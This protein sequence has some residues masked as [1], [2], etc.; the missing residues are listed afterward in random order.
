MKIVAL[1]RI[2][3]GAILAVSLRCPDEGEGAQP[4]VLWRTAYGCG[5]DC[6]THRTIAIDYYLQSCLEN[7]STLL[8]MREHEHT[9][10][11][12][13]LLTDLC[14][15][16]RHVGWQREAC[17]YR[18]RQ[19]LTSNVG[20]TVDILSMGRRG[21]LPATS[22]SAVQQAPSHVAL[23]TETHTQHSVWFSLSD[24]GGGGG[25][26]AAR[27]PGCVRTHQILRSL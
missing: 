21:S 22:L 1:N 20:A 6:K 11:V 14:V 4:L 23:C 18:L 24:G 8:S 16:A 12:C 13:A 2:E 15:P 9:E 3:D 27:G 25:E 26:G 17:S 7:R 5:R 10:S 19:L